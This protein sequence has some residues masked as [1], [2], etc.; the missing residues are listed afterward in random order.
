[1]SSV[2]LAA[3]HL[4][5]SKIIHNSENKI[6]STWKIIEEEKGRTKNKSDIQCIKIND[7]IIYNQEEIAMTFSNYFLSIADSINNKNKRYGNN[8]NQG[9]YLTNPLK[10][11]MCKIKWKYVTTHEI[12]KII[13][14]LKAKNSHGFDEISNKIIKVSSRFIISPLTYICN[15]ILKTG[16]FPD[17][18]KYAI[19]KP[20]FKKGKKSDIANYRPILLLTSFAK[21]IEKIIYNRLLLHLDSN[22]ILAPEQFGFR[23]NSSTEQ[24]AYIMINHILTAL[25][26]KL[27][28]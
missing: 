4:H 21:I 5:Y 9:K 26:D 13:R 8:T 28:V 10:K 17:R 12:E 2:I 7:T 6:K 11:D 19:V 20:I 18:L 15:E 27:L 14:S 24:A 22:N 16:T 1:M 25:N 3:K 23:S